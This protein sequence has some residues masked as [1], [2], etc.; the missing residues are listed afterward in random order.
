MWASFKYGMATYAITEKESQRIFSKL[1]R[2]LFPLMGIHRKFS[3]AVATLPAQYLGL[4][5]PDPYIESRIERISIFVTNMGAGTLT[6]QFIEV[7]LQSFQLEIGIFENVLEQDFKQWKF[8]A[9]S[10][11]IKSLWEFVSRHGIKIK[12]PMQ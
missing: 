2:P 12:S 3:S 11:W 9:T 8:L 7:S 10:S 5:I 6:A 4:G 1:L